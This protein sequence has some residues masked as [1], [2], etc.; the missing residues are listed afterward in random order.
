MN[1]AE[2]A[3]VSSLIKDIEDGKLWLAHDE[4]RTIGARLENIH[5]EVI[6]DE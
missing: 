4:M 5:K 1:R 6:P 2:L 3:W